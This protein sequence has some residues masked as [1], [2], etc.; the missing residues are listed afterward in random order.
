VR[1]RPKK[2]W[3]SLGLLALALVVGLLSRGDDPA[4]VASDRTIEDL[5]RARQSGV[6][7][8]GSGVVVKLLPDDLTGAKHQRFLLR[9]ESGLSLLVSHN[10]DLADRV[11]DLAVGAEVA[12]RGQY[13]WN[14][15]GGV[16][17]WTHH[18]P[19]GRRPGGWLRTD[20]RTYR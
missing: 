4:T 5:H 17:H 19:G 14:D 7:V 9:L 8:E 12:F 20:G 15:K 13:E 6:V 1:S 11:S 18:D 3:G 16:V 10:I 2:I